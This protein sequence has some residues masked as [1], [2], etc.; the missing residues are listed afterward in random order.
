MQ[1]HVG[2]KG[3]VKLPHDDSEEESSLLR[4]FVVLSASIELWIINA[5]NIKFAL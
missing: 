5:I 1:V 3:T 4:G 2:K